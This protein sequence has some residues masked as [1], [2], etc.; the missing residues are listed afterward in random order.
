[1]I[2]NISQIHQIFFTKL[3]AVIIIYFSYKTTNSGHHPRDGDHLSTESVNRL[4]K[5]GVGFLTKSFPHQNDG[6][7]KSHQET[8]DADQLTD[9][10]QHKIKNL[11]A[12]HANETLS[13][14]ESYD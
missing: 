6:Y 3:L 12:N 13:L 14:A 5:L 9:P 4:R 2:L 11:G 8:E 1:M 10:K 7:R